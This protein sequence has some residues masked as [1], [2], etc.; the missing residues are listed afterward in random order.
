M[1]F[2][3]CILSFLFVLQMN[4]IFVESLH[5]FF[6]EHSHTAKILFV[7]NILFYFPVKMYNLNNTHVLYLKAKQQKTK[8]TP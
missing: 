7:L 1:S 4:I 5:N 2:S 3:T 6:D 8:N